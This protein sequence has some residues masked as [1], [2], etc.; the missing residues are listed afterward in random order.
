MQPL[1]LDSLVGLVLEDDIEILELLGEGGMGLVYRAQQHS[2]KREICIK[3]MRTELIGDIDSA[4]RFRREATALS[5]IQDDHIVRVY[6]V[7]LLY[8]VY[9]YIAMEFVRGE[10]L[11]ELLSSDRRIDW[12]RTSEICVQICDAMDR[13][14]KQGFVHRDL[15][16][17]NII[18]ASSHQEAYVKILDF[19]ICGVTESV[20]GVT[21]LTQTGELIGSVFYMAPECFRQSQRDPSVDQYAIGCIFYEA[22]SGSP[23]FVGGSALELAHKH[24]A[25][26]VP[27]LPKDA[28]SDSVRSVLDR[29]VAK[30]CAKE[31]RN[32]FGDCAEMSD[33]LRAVLGGNMDDTIVAT[34]VKPVVRPVSRRWHLTCLVAVTVAVV[35]VVLNIGT[36]VS[37]AEPRFH[38]FRVDY[39]CWMKDEKGLLREA[40]QS[41][42]NKE[43]VRAARYW[44]GYL[45]CLCFRRKNPLARINVL[46]RL[47]DSEMRSLQ[48]DQACRYTLNALA[49]IQLACKDDSIKPD[50]V[51]CL[52]RALELLHTPIS[53]VSNTEDAYKRLTN[54]LTAPAQ[55]QCIS[56]LSNLVEAN[57]FSESLR[58]DLIATIAEIEC[59]R[60]N[61][62]GA[63]H[64]LVT[65]AEISSL[66]NVIEQFRRDQSWKFKGKEE[67]S[68]VAQ[69]VANVLHT[70]PSKW[71]AS[72]VLRMA[73]LFESE[74]L[75]KNSEFFLAW[76]TTANQ[77]DYVD[78]LEPSLWQFCKLNQKNFESY[79][80]G[81][82]EK[83]AVQLNIAARLAV[84]RGPDLESLYDDYRA[85][86]SRLIDPA[87]SMSRDLAYDF[88][89]AGI[90]QIQNA[91]G[92]RD[93][94]AA[95]NSTDKLMGS[96]CWRQIANGPHYTILTGPKD[97]ALV[98]LGKVFETLL[99]T[100]PVNGLTKD[101]IERLVAQ[102]FAIDRRYYN[103][104]QGAERL[105]TCLILAISYQAG[106]LIPDDRELATLIRADKRLTLCQRVNLLGAL[107]MNSGAD[108]SRTDG[109]VITATSEFGREL[110]KILAE[111]IV[112]DG[113]KE[114]P[115][116]PWHYVDYTAHCL[117]FRLL[118]EGVR[119]RNVMDSKVSQCRLPE[120]AFKHALYSLRLAVTMG[121]LARARSD[122]AN[123]VQSA[124]KMQITTSSTD[125]AVVL[126]SKDQMR[127]LQDRNALN[128]LKKEFERLR[129]ESKERRV[130][131][132]QGITVPN[133]PGL[134]QHQWRLAEVAS[135]LASRGVIND[136]REQSMIAS[137]LAWCII[138]DI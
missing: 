103:L 71:K 64:A 11:R 105:E 45:S 48:Y 118:N 73:R 132:L 17:D 110:Y 28:A 4:K 119:V 89:D 135:E 61:F 77:F 117:N 131:R 56:L 66:S 75:F 96:D 30:A 90:K 38:E 98:R 20:L 92:R 19:G 39:Y 22:L 137:L 107:A 84:A 69:M 14:H 74:E 32:R 99:I 7:G 58:G 123:A 78:H 35:L 53:T 115:E 33:C 9:P 102:W 114:S 21:T 83:T 51:Q 129:V 27:L 125:D 18:L 127:V 104:A 87:L 68:L 6:F 37:F 133:P 111:M 106:R 54:F 72:V 85:A 5:E 23:P 60:K 65:L 109:G 50:A 47:A 101:R 2:L 40:E 120:I 49:E 80:K 12:R 136:D 3:F 62:V 91:M 10:L 100:S 46:L 1:K 86:T 31:P 124:R 82:A 81:D 112:A 52:V 25:A 8:D 55:T 94:L 97:S 95:V 116:I 122:A 13:V 79:T 138:Y 63:A 26:A 67:Q 93:Y 15:K 44:K 42:E 128:I 29:I 34:L 130:R 126:Q 41:F 134:Q 76:L 36:V 108:G 57:R 59:R 121:D 43:Y 88:I 24:A 113:Q 16:P 70:R